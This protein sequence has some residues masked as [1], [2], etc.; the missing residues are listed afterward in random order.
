[1]KTNDDVNIETDVDTDTELA[2][3]F[4]PTLYPQV[5]RVSLKWKL[6]MLGFGLLLEVGGFLG[7]GWFLLDKTLAGW[8][9]VFLVALCVALAGL[10]GYGSLYVLQYRVVLTTGAIEV[11]GPLRRRRSLRREDIKGRQLISSARGISTLVFVPVGEHAKKLEVSLLWETDEAFHRWYFDIPDVDA[12]EF[13]DSEERLARHRY[14]DLSP[15][16]G[17]ARTARLRR[18]ATGVNSAAIVLS[19]G[20][21]LSPID[22]GHL[23]F[24]SLLASP[25]VVIGLVARFQPL[26]RFGGRSSDWHPDLSMRSSRRGSFW[27]CAHCPQSRLSLGKGPRCWRAW[28]DW[29][30]LAPQQVLTHGFENCA[31]KCSFWG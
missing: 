8:A 5:Y 18:L 24:A 22:P 17:A 2:P 26:Y 13:A 4:D 16:D 27:H 9:A 29:R 10:G 20:Y 21:L 11:F 31:G 6:L 15:E 12:Q 3:A 14:L 23:L 30:W 25:W 19:A 1:M 28:A 7:A